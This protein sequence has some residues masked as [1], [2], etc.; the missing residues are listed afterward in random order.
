MSDLGD[1]INQAVQT[2]IGGGVLVYPTE[3]VWGIGCDY[4][5]QDAVNK[6][7]RLKQRQVS[8][9]LVLIASHIQ[10]V[11]P[12]IRPEQSADLA[13]ALKTWPGHFTWVFP[14]TELVP[15]WI[16]GDFDT[17]AVRVSAHP[18]VK[19][20]CDQLGMPMVSTSANV[21]GE[22]EAADCQTLKTTWGQAVDYYLDRPLG[23]AS[24][25]SQIRLAADGELIR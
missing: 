1:S 7:L 16:S 21:S 17:V 15:A 9:G 4:R 18:V 19:S 12:L 14:K 24:G 22:A 10:Q 6:V 20:L 5:D 11:L 13:R 8:K 23:Q 2:I 3:G 25:S